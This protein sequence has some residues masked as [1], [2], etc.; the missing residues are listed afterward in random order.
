MKHLRKFYESNGEECT[1]KDFKN[2]MFDILDDFNF[3]YQFNDYSSDK[4]DPFFDCQIYILK[5]SEYYDKYEMPNLN[6]IE[7][8]DLRHFDEPDD[9][10][11]LDI[12]D[13]K[14]TINEN[15][16]KI[17]KIVTESDE[18]IKYHKNIKSLLER[19]AN[20]LI[21]RFEKYDNFDSCEIGKNDE[22]LRICFLI[23]N[24]DEDENE[25]DE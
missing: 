12:N 15:I 2:I 16:S 23:K 24:E 17:E 10:S 8:I 5:N 13:I 11:R 20:D 7:Y 1:F 4:W 25:D 19:L 6:N 22:F 21:P 3:E 9:L 14:I 18:I